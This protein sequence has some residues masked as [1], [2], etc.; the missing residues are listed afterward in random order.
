MFEDPFGDSPFKAVPSPETAPFPPQMHQ[1]LEPSESSG[2]NTENVSNF[3]FGDSFSVVPYSTSS[4]SDTQLVSSN[5]QFLPQYL[6]SPPQEPDILAD[7][8]PPA[9]LSGITSQ[10][11]FSAPP[12]YA[13][14][15]PSFSASSGQMASQ[16]FLAQSGQL[17][18][19]GF[20]AY[21]ASQFNSRNFIAQ[22]GNVPGGNQSDVVGSLL[23]EGVNAPNVCQP[24]NDKFETKS[25]VW[26]DT[27][28]R[29][30]VNLNISGREC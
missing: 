30:L 9:P 5:S 23:G 15:L 26:A 10:H 24:S 21:Q 12:S 29:G 7:I 22:Q 4:V 1:N 27:L 18:Q 13:Q 2:P 8:L 17:M 3:G 28:S 6:S 16:Y 14:S 20:S 25:T 11:N 19:Q